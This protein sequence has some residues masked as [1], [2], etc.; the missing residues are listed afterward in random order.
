MIKKG[1]D[2][3]NRKIIVDL[4]FA[5]SYLEARDTAAKKELKLAGNVL[6][7]GWSIPRDR[8]VCPGKRFLI[9]LRG[10]GVNPIVQD[11]RGDIRGILVVHKGGESLHMI[12]AEIEEDKVGKLRFFDGRFNTAW[13]RELL[14]YPEPNGLFVRG[15]DIIDSSIGPFADSLKRPWIL[16]WSEI[17]RFGV[18][19]EFIG[20]R[21]G[22]F[23]D[24]G[25]KP[26][27]VQVEK[28]QGHEAVIIHPESII[29]L[30]SF[31][32]TP[33]EL[34]GLI[35]DNTKVPLFSPLVCDRWW[36]T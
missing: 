30:R 1:E 13:A 6:L 7:D 36:E 5:S 17:V 33:D 2:M 12:A 18:T 23:V 4:G 14:V 3:R 35:D 22:L 24:P 29:L 11:S 34:Y 32:Q 28:Y 15:R 10:I 31:I 26:E 8:M 9:R 27:G 20:P 21:R 16:P 25:D 19:D